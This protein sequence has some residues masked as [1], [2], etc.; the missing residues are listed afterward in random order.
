LA[1]NRRTSRKIKGLETSFDAEQVHR[2]EA[3]I[4][5]YAMVNDFKVIDIGATSPACGPCQD[6]IG[7]TGTNLST[8][9]KKLPP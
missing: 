1:E 9:I 2:A 7:P 4:I 5:A 8:P 6:L 3:D